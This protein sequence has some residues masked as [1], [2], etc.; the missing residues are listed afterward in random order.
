MAAAVISNTSS[1]I[2][3]PLVSQRTT[4][5]APASAAVWIARSEY[6]AI[7]LPAVEEVLGVEDHLAAGVDHH[8]HAVAD[9]GEVFVQPGANHL[10][11]L[12]GGGLAHE[13]D[14]RGLG[15]HQG[16]QAGVVLGVGSLCGA[17]SRTRR[18]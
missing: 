7:V 8:S 14:D 16:P 4:S 10:A 1:H 6:S 17:S 2:V 5:R 12:K 11:S 13:R 3:P 15:V 9:H 18:L